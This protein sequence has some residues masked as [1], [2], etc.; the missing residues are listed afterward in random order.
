MSID[1]ACT[2]YVNGAVNKTI[3]VARVLHGSQ[4]HSMFTITLNFNPV[5]VAGELKTIKVPM[6]PMQ[7]TGDCSI[8]SW[9]MFPLKP[10][11]DSLFYHVF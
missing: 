11:D 9:L 7:L 5:P 3:K 1:Y 10:G 8:G 2:Y 4:T 6:K